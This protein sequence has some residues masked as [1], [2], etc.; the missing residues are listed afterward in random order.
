MQQAPSQRN[1][2]IR[3]HGFSSQQSINIAHHCR[4]LAAFVV[5]VHE[6]NSSSRQM[7]VSVGHAM[8]HHA[9]KNFTFP[10]ANFLR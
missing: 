2:S 8:V 5:E 3:K 1:I 7:V 6:T 10:L 4:L 9:L